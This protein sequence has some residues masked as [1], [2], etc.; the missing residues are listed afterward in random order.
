MAN[1]AGEFFQAVLSIRVMTLFYCTNDFFEDK[2]DPLD[3]VGSLNKYPIVR[4]IKLDITKPE[5]I[6]P[7]IDNAL[8]TFGRIDILFN[9]FCRAYA[10]RS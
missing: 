4:T 1:K 2:Y 9:N 5:T 6:Q 7:A 3:A 10:K 8:K